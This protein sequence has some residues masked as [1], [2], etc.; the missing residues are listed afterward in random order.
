MLPPNGSNRF[1][2]TIFTLP[3]PA[4]GAIL[5]TG[6]QHM[7]A[8][9]HDTHYLPNGPWILCLPLKAVLLRRTLSPTSNWVHL[10]L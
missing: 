8:P 2:C 1:Q 5:K 3:S 10:I 9:Q 6:N 7:V 4:T